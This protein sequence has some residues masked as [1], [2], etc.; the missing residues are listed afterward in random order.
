MSIKSRKIE[1]IEKALL[2]GS[3][4]EWCFF[5]N[6]HFEHNALPEIDFHTIE[7]KSIFLEK[8]LTAPIIIASMTGGDPELDVYNKI[9]A[10]AAE[11]KGIAL[12]IG[13]QRIML[14]DEA[15]KISFENIKQYAQSIPLLANIGAVQ[16]NY[17]VTPS[18]CQ[19]IID[20]LKADALCIHLNPMQEVLQKEGNSNFSNLLN[21]IK[22]VLDYINVPIIIKEVGCGISVSVAEKLRKIG[23]KYIDIAGLGGTSWNYIE[24]KRENQDTV[25]ADWG[26]P[27]PEAIAQ[28]S[29]LEGIQIIG[30]GGIRSGLDIAK[31]IALGANYVSIGLPFLQA[32]KISQT[33]VE[34]LIDKYIHELKVS[35]FG[36]GAKKLEELQKIGLTHRSA[37]TRYQDDT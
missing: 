10:E 17:D 35:M 5:D 37:P 27:T 1:H 21:K 15:R 34:N 31:A 25:F 19:E 24:A 7:T 3:D 29:K 16:L 36:V 6:Y 33:A 18:C 22:E 20:T 32:A 13:S 8:K 11:K 2:E 12:A 26:I 9:L 28:C 14:E 23:I 4:R 30:G